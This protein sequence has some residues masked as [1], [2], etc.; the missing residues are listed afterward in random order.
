MPG[1]KSSIAPKRITIPSNN[2]LPGICPCASIACNLVQV[3]NP[4]D[5]AKYQP[6]TPVKRI[7][8]KV[9]KAPNFCPNTNSK[10]SSTKGST[11]KTGKKRS[12]KKPPPLRLPRA[13]SFLRKELV[14]FLLSNNT[15]ILFDILS[16]I[17]PQK[18]HFF[19]FFSDFLL[20]FLIRPLRNYFSL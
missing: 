8:L 3:A 7:Q 6:R 15:S 9:N 11:K 20:F 18:Q 4:C 1:V 19:L 12:N 17:L 2:S 10:Y 5:C 16:L 14:H 13:T